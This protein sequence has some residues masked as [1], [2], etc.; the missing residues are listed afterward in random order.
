[1][2]DPP[3]GAASLSTPWLEICTIAALV[4]LWP[5]GFV[6]L[7]TSK[8]WTTRDRLVAILVPPGGYFGLLIF[9]LLSTGPLSARP[10]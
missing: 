9:G 6:L 4:L 7:W 8:T 10:V 5:V 3:A 1:M 2:G